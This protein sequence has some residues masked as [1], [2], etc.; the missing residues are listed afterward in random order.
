MYKA[1]V[2]EI[3]FT[4]NQIA[5]LASDIDKGIYGELSDDL[6][7]AILEEGAK[8]ASEEI[9]PMNKVGDEHHSTLKD[10]VVTTPPGWKDMYHRWIEGGWNLDQWTRWWLGI[11]QNPRARL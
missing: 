1:P 7:N 10:G 5:D 11:A 9:A 6:V 2:G 8:F 4:L 3:A